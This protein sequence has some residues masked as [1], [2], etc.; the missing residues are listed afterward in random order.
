[1]SYGLHHVPAFNR[2]HAT[3][4]L[5]LLISAVLFS[6]AGIFV[7]GVSAGA[8][9]IIFWRGLFA[10]TF[11]T[12]YVFYRG[13]TRYE[14]CEMGKPG[15]VAAVI[16]ALGTMAFI[17]AFKHTSIANVSLI[18]A[19]S[20]FIAA[21]MMWLWTNEKPGVPILASSVLALIGVS[22]IFMG[23]IGAV[24]IT[25]DMLALTMTIA[26]AFFVCIYRRY[27]HTPAAGPAVLLSII[28]V[29]IAFVFGDP[30][31]ASSFEILIMGSFGLVFSIASVTL[32]EGAKRLPAAE[33]ALISSLETPLA[34]LWAWMFLGGAIILLAVYGSQFLG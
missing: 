16:G 1:V 21:A 31:G 26:L 33:T 3:G 23:S 20:P 30:F 14:F 12:C 11:T 8:W 32:A 25:G 10:A 22:V 5:L 9:E 18:Y 6:S 24:Y 27:P 17:P 7:K 29:I 2:M 28:L 4:V 13:A 19:A 15:M 34:P